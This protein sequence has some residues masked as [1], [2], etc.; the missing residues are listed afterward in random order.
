M[1]E[2]HQKSLDFLGYPQYSI[3]QD[4]E[5]FSRY[6]SKQLRENKCSKYR[7]V[8]LYNNDGHKT[9]LV[10]RLVALAFLPNPYNYE[11]VDHI[12]YNI[13]NNCVANLRWLPK[14][15]NSKRS[16]DD[17][18]HDGQKVC[19]CQFNLDG[20]LLNKFNS[21]QEAANEIG[22]DRSNISRAC[23]LGRKC[24]GYIWTYDNTEGWCDNE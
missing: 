10:H 19:I 23:S 24:K 9:F 13:E 4:G 20:K 17:K 11:T 5:V 18:N 15:E 1:M 7:Q 3:S 21:I 22:C 14:C 16:W 2:I 6:S 8:T 12:D